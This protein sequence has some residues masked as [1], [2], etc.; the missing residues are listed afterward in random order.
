M[1]TEDI[2]TEKQNSKNSQGSLQAANS[3]MET[4]G[5]QAKDTGMLKFHDPADSTTGDAALNVQKK[6]R[7]VEKKADADEKLLPAQVNKPVSVVQS[8]PGQENPGDGADGDGADADGA[9]GDN[10]ENLD[11]ESMLAKMHDG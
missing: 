7:N 9:D 3:A 2:N 1:A 10:L 5:Q 6:P 4:D 11:L 8:E